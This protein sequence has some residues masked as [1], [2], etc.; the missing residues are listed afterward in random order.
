VNVASLDLDFLLE[1]PHFRCVEQLRESTNMVD[2]F[3]QLI[4]G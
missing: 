3:Q 1:S 2:S 4:G